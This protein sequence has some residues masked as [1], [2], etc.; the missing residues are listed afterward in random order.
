MKNSFKI[1]EKQAFAYANYQDSDSLS[2]ASF[3]TH[4]KTTSETYLRTEEGYFCTCVMF[5]N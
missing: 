4:Q 1:L 2:H 3:P 5:P